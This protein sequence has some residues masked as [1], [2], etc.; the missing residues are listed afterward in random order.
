MSVVVEIGV[1]TPRILRRDQW[2]KTHFRRMSMG[3]ISICA[4]ITS[5]WNKYSGGGTGFSAGVAVLILSAVRTTL[6]LLSKRGAPAFELPRW[7]SGR[8]VRQAVSG[9][10]GATDATAA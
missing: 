10:Q 5:W 9:M 6:G 4:S 1:N 8:A 7:K 3:L 2:R